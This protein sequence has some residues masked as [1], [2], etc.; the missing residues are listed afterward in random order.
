MTVP[1]VDLGLRVLPES[2]FDV[3]NQIIATVLAPLN[4]VAGMVGLG[5]LGAWTMYRKFFA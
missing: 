2:L 3:E 5:V 4:S 1:T